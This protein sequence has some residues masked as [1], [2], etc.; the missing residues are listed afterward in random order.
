MGQHI[1]LNGK[2]RDP[3]LYW[4]KTWNSTNTWVTIVTLFIRIIFQLDNNNISIQLL[5][6]TITFVLTLQSFLKYLI[7]TGIMIA[8]V[9]LLLSPLFPGRSRTTPSVWPTPSRLAS[10]ASAAP[11]DPRSPGPPL[12]RRSGAS[13]AAGIE[14]GWFYRGKQWKSFSFTIEHDV[15]WQFYPQKTWQMVIQ[16]S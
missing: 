4:N 3:L 16:L 12:A 10:R 5:K 14:N 11:N 6:H 8:T 7:I 13:R 9:W 1:S 15:K 2:T